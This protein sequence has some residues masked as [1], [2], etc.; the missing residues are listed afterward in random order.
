MQ[1]T[2]I[3]ADKIFDMIES[4][5]DSGFYAEFSRQ[6][7][8]GNKHYSHIAE[9]LIAHYGLEDAIA[10]SYD[11]AWALWTQAQSELENLTRGAK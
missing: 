10:E 4:T 1:N 6:A 11:A 7:V 8:L 5:E 9:L 3:D 2:K